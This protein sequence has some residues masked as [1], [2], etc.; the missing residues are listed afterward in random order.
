MPEQP[1]NAPER[2]P[3]FKKKMSEWLK[4]LADVAGIVMDLRD[5]P[6]RAD[7]LSAGFRAANMAAAWYFGRDSRVGVGTWDYFNDDLAGWE[8]FPHEHRMLVPELAMNPVVAPEWLD[9]DDKSPYVCLAKLGPEVV[10][11]VNNADGALAN[12]PYYRTDRRNET[13]AELGKLAW[14]HVGT[15]HLAYDGTGMVADSLR[16]VGLRTQQ[17]DDLLD[18]VQLYLRANIKR[19]YLLT[20]APGTGKSVAIRWLTG[21]LGMNSVRV[22]VGVLS[23]EKNDVISALDSMLRI[24]S[25]DVLILDDIDRI[26]VNAE[27]L[28]FL[29]MARRS[30]RL[31]I[32][33]AN[34]PSK[35]SG[36]ALR[37]GRLDELI[38]FKFLDPRVVVELL[39][40]FADLVDEVEDLPAAYITEFCNRCKVLGR[41][42]ALAGLGE[43]RERA[44]ET[45]EDSD[46][47]WSDRV[48]EMVTR[49]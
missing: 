36:A 19:S 11:W 31:V 5:K 9:A 6:T 46:D 47:W 21:V 2:K 18:R 1:K 40:E 25:P 26:D 16:D 48:A 20:G 7:Y 38:E 37:P 35:L 27:M 24:F 32:A 8:S 15:K 13:Y 45:S 17:L 42:V 44:E 34:Q 3:S 10:G 30:C 29:E 22:N 49:A 43:L 23:S 28:T 12:G 39:G 4:V 14:K 41:D 33:S